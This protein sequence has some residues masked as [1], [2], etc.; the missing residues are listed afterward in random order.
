[1]LQP[2]NAPGFPWTNR[3]KHERWRLNPEQLVA[4]QPRLFDNA[5]MNEHLRIGLQAIWALGLLLI[6]A[7]SRNK[8]DWMGK[9]APPISP[10]AIEDGSGSQPVGLDV[11]LAAIVPA[12]LIAASQS[13]E[14]RHQD[15]LPTPPICHLPNSFRLGNEW[16]L[17]RHS[18][19]QRTLPT[20]TFSQQK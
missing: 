9:I 10:S 11:V 3:G 18:L 4:L 15:R 19:A 2:G 12:Q 1:M 20:R 8:Y 5:P 14:G 13:R 7:F 6:F 17:F 16:P